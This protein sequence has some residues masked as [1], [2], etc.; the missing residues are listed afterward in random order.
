MCR[1]QLKYI[2]ACLVLTLCA[3]GKKEESEETT[4]STAAAV[5]ETAAASTSSTTASSADT[6]SDE[7]KEALT[8]L[9]NDDLALNHERVSTDKLKAND[10][11]F[12]KSGSFVTAT[13]YYAKETGEGAKKYSFQYIYEVNDDSY[14]Y[15]SSTVDGETLTAEQLEEKQNST[16]SD[17][18]QDEKDS[19]SKN[20]DLEEVEAD[21][22]TEKTY[23]LKNV[24]ESITIEG[25]HGGDGLYV[26]EILD[27]EGNV[28]ACPFNDEGDVSESR[29]SEVDPG[30]YT[31]RMRVTSGTWGISYNFT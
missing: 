16:D 21:F 15:F 20:Q 10:I 3:C 7:E 14:Y 12:K 13:G 8:T 9:I 19:E 17:K 4:S 27:S 30:D 23:E 6:V 5:Q 24:K 31:V 26:V 25:T 22:T 11:T 2:A 29:T 1:K 28:V 18:D